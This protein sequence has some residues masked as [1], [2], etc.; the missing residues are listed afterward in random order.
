MKAA[1]TTRLV[2]HYKEIADGRQQEN[3]ESYLSR[4]DEDALGAEERSSFRAKMNPLKMLLNKQGP[5]ALKL[6]GPSG[7]KERPAGGT[8]LGERFPAIDE[9]K[10]ERDDAEDKKHQT[11]LLKLG[12]LGSFS[13]NKGLSPAGSGL[14]RE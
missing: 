14:Q 2:R 3:I 9:E 5:P 10:S 11:P 8:L 12:A 4:I 1:V 6:A 7:A 13:Q